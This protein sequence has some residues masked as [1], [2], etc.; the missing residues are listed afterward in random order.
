MKTSY[1]NSLIHICLFCSIIP[2]AVAQQKEIKGAKGVGVVRNITPA[3][4]RVKAIEEAKIEAL[5]MAGVNEVVRSFDVL[6]KKEDQKQ[7]EEYF[8]SLVS[9]QSQGSVVDWEIVSEKT[10]VDENSN[11]TIEVEINATVKKYKSLSDPSFQFEVAGL[12]PSYENEE[13]LKFSI[14]PNQSGFIRVFIMDESNQMYMLFPNSSEKDNRL[15]EKKSYRF[16][17]VNYHEYVAFTKKKSEVNYIIFLLTK[18]D[19]PYSAG[20]SSS[21]K[22]FVN[23]AFSVEPSN[24]QMT[25]EKIEIYK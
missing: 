18:S 3:Q 6:E 4:A 10:S 24:R 12:R 8:F 17:T 9:V 5:R 20:E 7:F 11:I 25:M 2:F 15:L 21:F 13:A 1:L 14:K 16:P 22:D 19:V 23:Y